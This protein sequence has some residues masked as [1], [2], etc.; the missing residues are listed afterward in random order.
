MEALIPTIMDTIVKAGIPALFLL[1]ALVYFFKEN[2]KLR[3]ILDG[4]PAKP[5]DK[6]IRGELRATEK[7]HSA[8]MAAREKAHARELELRRRGELRRE[9]RSNKGLYAVA[10]ILEDPK[11]AGPDPDTVDEEQI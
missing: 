3:I 6:G 5:E 9:R 7:E 1:A 8:A 2:K 4:D 11:D 10:D